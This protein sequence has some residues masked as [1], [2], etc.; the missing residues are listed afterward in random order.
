MGI[1]DLHGTKKENQSLGFLESV[2]AP[3]CRGNILLNTQAC[4]YTKNFGRCFTF[5]N[6]EWSSHLPFMLGTNYTRHYVAVTDLPS[7]VL[8][9]MHNGETIP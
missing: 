5:R 1:H 2:A 6:M 7:V 9:I 8:N 3:L 4:T